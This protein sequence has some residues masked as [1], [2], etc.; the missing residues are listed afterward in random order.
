MALASTEHESCARGGVRR[1]G[2]DDGFIAAHAEGRGDDVVSF[3]GWKKSAIGPSTGVARAMQHLRK[4]FGR[5]SVEAGTTF[6]GAPIGWSSPVQHFE[7]NSSADAAESHTWSPTRN[8]NE[9]SS[10]SWR[11]SRA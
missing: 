7:N 5:E 4:R 1:S 6:M 8:C 2:A 9:T 11:G 3:D 10:T